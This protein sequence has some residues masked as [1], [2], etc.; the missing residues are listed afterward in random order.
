[1]TTTKPMLIQGAAAVMTGRAGANAR[2]GAVDIR[3]R[4]GRVAELA[5][6]HG[7]SK[8]WALVGVS[9]V[10]A[11]FLI[12]SFYSVIGGWS[13]NYTLGSVLGSFNGQD[14]DSIGALFSGMLGSPTALL[15]WHTAFMVLVV[16]IV[17]RGV[18]KGLESA[19][20]TMMPA[21]VVLMLVLHQVYS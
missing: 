17:A 7:R 15:L 21:L 20:R 1:M 18:T 13:L 6:N 19:A 14:A 16:G 8:A 10:L 12:L 2:A 3:I 11:A 5:A 9:G 4:D